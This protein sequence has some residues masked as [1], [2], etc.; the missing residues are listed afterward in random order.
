MAPH[1]DVPPVLHALI[2]LANR[3]KKAPSLLLEPTLSEE[4]IPPPPEPDQVG[5][6]R[7]LKLLDPLDL[8]HEEEV[9][10]RPPALVES[11]VRFLAQPFGIWLLKSFLQRPLEGFLSPPIRML[12][13]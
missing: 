3:V 7:E 6:L 13:L 8:L 5:P 12:A 1:T 4:D 2:A 10:T 11:I 9:R